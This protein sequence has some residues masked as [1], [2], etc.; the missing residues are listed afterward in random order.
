MP[1]LPELLIEI[2][3]VLLAIPPVPAYN[4]QSKKYKDYIFDT[5]NSSNCYY[6]RIFN[7]NKV[8]DL[9]NLAIKQNPNSESN[10]K[11]FIWS[12]VTFEQWFMSRSKYIAN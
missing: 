3:V 11:H 2:P 1:T 8:L 4:L 10:L 9:F 7:K 12:I 5:L 6:N